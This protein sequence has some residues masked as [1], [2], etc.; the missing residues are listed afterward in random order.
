MKIDLKITKGYRGYLAIKKGGKKHIKIYYRQQI[1]S[2]HQYLRRTFLIS[3]K[4]RANRVMK[5]IHGGASIQ[6]SG[7]LIH[8]LLGYFFIRPTNLRT[9]EG[10]PFL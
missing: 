2:P 5:M 3:G 9:T 6:F 1:N 7:G 10:N 8:R 4:R